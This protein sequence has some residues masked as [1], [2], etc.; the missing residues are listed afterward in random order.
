MPRGPWPRLTL[1]PTL[2]SVCR[3]IHG[4]DHPPSDAGDLAAV[5][6]VGARL[7]VVGPAEPRGQ[8]VEVPVGA[9]AVDENLEQ[10]GAVAHEYVVHEPR[11]VGAHHDVGLRGQR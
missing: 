9:A 7:S 11:A 2:P 6:R 5:D 10:R 4:L 3:E 1:T 8:V